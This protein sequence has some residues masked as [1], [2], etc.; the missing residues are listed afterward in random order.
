MAIKQNIHL[1]D[2][3]LL[4]GNSTLYFNYLGFKPS[5]FFWVFKNLLSLLLYIPDYEAQQNESVNDKIL[6]RVPPGSEIY[7]KLKK[8]SSKKNREENQIYRH[9]TLAHEPP[10]TL[11]HCA[12]ILEQYMGLGTN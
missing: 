7:T 10:N 8:A 5:N 3:F 4:I 6:E 1:L 12:G 9:E 11:S 2:I